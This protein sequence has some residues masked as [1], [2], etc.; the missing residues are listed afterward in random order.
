MVKLVRLAVLF[1]MSFHH[2]ENVQTINFG[3]L[4]FREGKVGENKEN[5]RRM[6]SRG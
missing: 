3:K 4:P 1:F 2:T 6:K 5:Q